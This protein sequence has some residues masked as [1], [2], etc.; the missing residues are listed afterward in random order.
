[1]RGDYDDSWT[2]CIENIKAGK[3]NIPYHGV[4]Y[5][6]ENLDDFLS[7]YADEQSP[8]PD[9]VR[10]ENEFLTNVPLAP[11]DSWT[12][13]YDFETHADRQEAKNDEDQDD[14]STVPSTK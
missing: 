6:S 4:V 2:K 11:E 9:Q 5:D 7:I 14:D 8:H 3:W 13:I 12:K 1:M 10:L